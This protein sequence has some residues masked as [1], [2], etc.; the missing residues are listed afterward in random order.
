MM[1]RNH[2]NIIQIPY[3]DTLAFQVEFFDE[4]FPLDIPLDGDKRTIEAHIR[5]NTGEL[6]AIMPMVS[7]E[8]PRPPQ[9]EIPPSNSCPPKD[10]ILSSFCVGHDL[11][12]TLAD[13][14]CGI[15]QKVEKNVSRCGGNGDCP[16][17]G[18][19]LSETCEGKTLVITEANGSCGITSRREPNS[20]SCGGDGT[21]CPMKGSTVREFC[22]GTTRVIEIA[23]GECNVS[24]TRE[25]N[26]PACNN[27]CPPKGTFLELLSCTPERKATYKEADGLCGFVIKEEE[28]SFK[29]GDKVVKTCQ[30]GTLTTTTTKEDGSQETKT[31]ANSPECDGDRVI[32]PPKPIPPK[33]SNPNPNP[34]TNPNPNLPGPR[35]YPNPNTPGMDGSGN[36]CT[37]GEKQPDGSYRG[38]SIGNLPKKP[39]QCQVHTGGSCEPHKVKK[40]RWLIVDKFGAGIGHTENPSEYI[41]KWTKMG[42]KEANGRTS[43]SQGDVKG[44][45]GPNYHFSN[46]EYCQQIGGNLINCLVSWTLQWDPEIETCNPGNVANP[47]RPDGL[48]VKYASLRYTA[49]DGFDE[50]G[51]ANEACQSAYGSDSSDGTPGIACGEG[52][53][54]NKSGNEVGGYNVKV[55]LPESESFVRAGCLGC[56]TLVGYEIHNGYVMGLYQ[57]WV[58]GCS[59]GDGNSYSGD[60]I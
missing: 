20:I 30:Q 45:Y 36:P 52:K 2:N 57:A 53:C 3:G 22:E 51:S 38:G 11:V 50:F 41:N 46:S 47:N 23:E 24:Q 44:L 25:P 59:N 31:E 4:Q 29:C 1:Y 34:P 28:D 32:T 39:K 17:A 7:H 35:P 13:G 33:P 18:T 9:E 26:S 56:K 40:K 19:R 8:L 21:P 55:Y 43:F 15:S 54:V 12:T 49:K 6:V 14:N 58:S 10:S 27:Q 5:T 42:L 16:P 60:V 37:L 48:Y